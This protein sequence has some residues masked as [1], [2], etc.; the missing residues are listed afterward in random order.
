MNI[1][2]ALPHELIPTMDQHI[3]ISNLLPHFMVRWGEPTGAEADFVP[4]LGSCLLENL[5]KIT[6]DDLNGGSTNESLKEHYQNVLRSILIP[7]GFDS[8][9][10][11]ALQDPVR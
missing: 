5:I 9:L 1:D 8:H 3:E 4:A 11:H 10:N 2:P 6:P 7:N